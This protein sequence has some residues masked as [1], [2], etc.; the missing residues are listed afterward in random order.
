[1]QCR[2]NSFLRATLLKEKSRLNLVRLAGPHPREAVHARLKN[3]SHLYQYVNVP[4]LAVGVTAH[5]VAES[6]LRSIEY[7]RLPNNGLGQ[8]PTQM[9]PHSGNYP[10]DQITSNFSPQACREM[11]KDFIKANHQN[12][13]QC[14]ASTWEYVTTTNSDVLTKGRQTWDPINERSVPSAQAYRELV[15]LYDEQQQGRRPTLLGLLNCFHEELGKQE[16]TIKRRERVTTT[17]NVRDPRTGLLIKV[18][19]SKVRVRTS[20]LNGEEVYQNC[21]QRAT[22]F[23]AYLKSKERGK[24]ERR[25]IASANMVLRAHLHIVEKFHLLLSDHLPGSVI[26]VGGDEKKNKILQVLGSLKGNIGPDELALQATEDVT[27]YNECLAPECFALF[28]NMIMD[29][30]L[31]RELGIP[32]VNKELEALSNIFTHT[33]Y[34]LASKRI[35]MGKGHT[36]ANATDMS[37][38][39]WT[40]ECLP[41]MND[42]TR[43]WYQK[44]ASHIEAGYLK[45]PY[46][47]LMGMLNAA[48]TTMALAAVDWR[49]EATTDCK[50]ARSSDDSMTVFSAANEKD[51]RV[52]IQ[53]LYDNL[54]LMGINISTKKTRFFRIGFGELTSW[55]QDGEFTGQYGV[56][57]SALRPVGNNPADDFHSVA[58]QT[59]TSLRTGTTNIFGAQARLC[60]GVDNCRR[61]WKVNK[62]PGKR[63]GVSGLVQVL[64]DGG[65]N[66][67]NWSTSHLPEIPLKEHYSSTEEEKRY[68]ERVMNPDNPFTAAPHET[69]TYSVE[70]GQLVDVEMDIPRNLFNLQ[71]RSNAT[72]RSLLRKEED[73]FKRVC[74]EINDT[75]EAV[76]PVSALVTP[77]TTTSMADSLSTQLT[78]E[79][80]ALHSASVSFT[81][82]ELAEIEAALELLKRD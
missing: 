28:H 8:R 20:T 12:I 43:E 38:M 60:I 46:G 78:A 35:W 4:P 50:T 73:D 59:N 48:S 69:T 14:L 27:K 51:L 32:L 18:T 36:V 13:D 41:M 39:N 53:R 55:Y 74:Q 70:L 57:T 34:L 64:S 33:F 67:W 61:L 1:M 65:L 7:N 37:N 77:R 3:I 62:A 24:L 22:S 16:L 44:A 68:L 15:R 63:P 5:K 49:K 26:G 56:E 81:P 45:A 29:N 19:K 80:G 58:S 6:V 75:F 40:D 17:E 31:R 79:R 2:A 54:R 42:V 23:C 11:F 47:M 52:N 66:P 76:D 71:K 10:F 72:R 21:F 9:W 82:E 25:A 30:D